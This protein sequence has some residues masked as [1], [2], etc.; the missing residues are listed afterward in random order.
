MGNK[1]NLL[2]SSRQMNLLVSRHRRTNANKTLAMSLHKI[3]ILIYI[4]L[5][6]INIASSLLARTLLCTGEV[7][8]LIPRFA[9]LIF[10]LFSTI[11]Q[12][13]LFQKKLTQY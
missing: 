13:Q 1:F 10:L 9:I 6:K 7:L 2:Y 11:L 4:V 12:K 3:S 5:L 8:S